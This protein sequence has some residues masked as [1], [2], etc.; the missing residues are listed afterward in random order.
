MATPA[1]LD[2]SDSAR[3]DGAPPLRLRLYVAGRS[4]NGEAAAATLRALI[5]E[6]SSVRIELETIDVFRD[7]GRALRDGAWATP[8]L[9]KLEPTPE[10]R[11]CG[12]LGDRATIIT[13]LGLG[14]LRVPRCASSCASSRAT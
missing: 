13:A 2:P 12:R 5:A 8:M 14:Q 1:L 11:M 7:P 4:P 10:R 9:I 3:I 6:F